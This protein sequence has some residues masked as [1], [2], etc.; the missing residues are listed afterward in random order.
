ML[1]TALTSLVQFQVSASQA[2]QLQQLGLI[3]S[4][5]QLAIAIQGSETV[6]SLRK[7]LKDLEEDLAHSGKL[8]D[9]AALL[10]LS[11]Q[12]D[13]VLLVEESGGM[14]LVDGSIREI[15]SGSN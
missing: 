2:H 7:R 10:G 14:V 8:V 5:V 12:P 1:Q 11:I 15:E 4:Q 3:T 6:A 9:V 13:A